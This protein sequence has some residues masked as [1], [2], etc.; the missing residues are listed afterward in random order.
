[1]ALHNKS[2]GGVRLEKGLA[3]P[4]ETL[5]TPL[6]D[7]KDRNGARFGASGPWFTLAESQQA[8]APAKG[9]LVRRGSPSRETD[10]L[11]SLK[12]W[13]HPRL[14]PETRKERDRHERAT[15]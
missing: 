3:D 4:L 14:T 6:L 9:S 13:R 7:L 15:V 8:Q 1:M 5:K 12:L 10:L 2:K 11:I